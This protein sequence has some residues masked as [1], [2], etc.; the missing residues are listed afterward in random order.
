MLRYKALFYKLL[1]SRDDKREY[2]ILN[3][4]EHHNVE[5]IFYT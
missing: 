2:E 1:F 3:D 4:A 5:I